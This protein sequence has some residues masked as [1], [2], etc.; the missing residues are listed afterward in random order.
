MFIV[1][2]GILIQFS[3]CLIIL[4][5]GSRSI[6]I[7]V[8][9]SVAN[10][11]I[12]ESCMLLIIGL[13]WR[14][15]VLLGILIAW[16]G[17]SLGILATQ[18]INMEHLTLHDLVLSIKWTFSLLDTAELFAKLSYFAL[19]FLKWLSKLTNG[20]NVFLVISWWKLLFIWLLCLEMSCRLLW[21]S[22]LWLVPSKTIL[23]CSF[24][25][26]GLNLSKWPSNRE[27]HDSNK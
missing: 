10:V 6:L 4:L 3:I 21:I 23:T 12:W 27:E 25:H 8:V 16:C 7:L 2:L 22:I 15:I 11:I 20:F 18:W 17:S 1:F 9:I 13:V 24:M 14:S 26:L 19:W 5:L